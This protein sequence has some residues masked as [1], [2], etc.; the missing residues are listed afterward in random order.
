MYVMYVHM[1]FVAPVC[2]DTTYCGGE[3]FTDDELSFEQCCFELS[4]VSFASPEHCLLCPIGSDINNVY[5]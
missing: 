1:C 4:G 5:L 2:F 3:S